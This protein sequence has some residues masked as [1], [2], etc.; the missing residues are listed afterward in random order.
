MKTW[1]V[2]INCD[3]GEGMGNEA[4]IFPFISSCNI[5][6]GG[7]AGD[8][9]S[10]R[11]VILLTQKYRVKIGAHPSYPDKANFGRE[12]MDIPADALIQSIRD[13]LDTFNSILKRKVPNCTISKRMAPCITKRQKTP[14]LRMS[15]WRPSRNI[16]TRPLFMP[17]L[18]LWWL[19]RPRP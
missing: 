7:H 5:A 13:Q 16:R 17:R 9:Q 3:V 10:M 15:I 6:C 18:G 12:V 19:V 8:V 11:E 1:Q 2:D 14:G 4:D